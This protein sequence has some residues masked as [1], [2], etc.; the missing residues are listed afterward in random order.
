MEWYAWVLGFATALFGGFAGGRWWGRRHSQGIKIE[1]G[2]VVD[3]RL[4]T[5]KE[6]S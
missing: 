3:A 4:C 2:C 5:D 1:C 6:K